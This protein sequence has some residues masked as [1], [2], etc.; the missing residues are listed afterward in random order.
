VLLL[1]G[2]LRDDKNL[3]GLLEALAMQR[4]PRIVLV[5]AGRDGARG[6][7][8]YDYYRGRI[9]ALG[10]DTRVTIL[11]RYIEEQEIAD[12]FALA[13]LCM[14]T[15]RREFTSQSGVLNTAAYY[16]VPVL[17]TPCA[18]L[19]EVIAQCHIGEVCGDDSADA[20][21]EG[22]GKLLERVEAGERFE[23]GDY[24]QRFSWKVNAR[25]TAEVYGAL[26]TKDA[27]AAADSKP[28]PGMRN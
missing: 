27:S 13:D 3:D 15:Y 26:L 14:L 10:L 12:L 24:R 1:F 18:C 5:C 7:R 2:N 11:D 19:R 21:A 4:D 22:L 17:A 9:A 25:I 16:S 20:I 23:F 28:A 6:H 8:T